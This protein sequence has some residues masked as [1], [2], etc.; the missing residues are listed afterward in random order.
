MD[1]LK[2]TKVMLQPNNWQTSRLFEY[3]GVARFAYNWALNREME[4]LSKG[5]GFISDGKLRKEFTQLKRQ[6]DYDWLNRVSNDVPK[7]AIIDLVN[8]FRKYF[9]KRKEP[10]YKPYSKKQIEHA[11][12][13][14]KKLTVYD[15][16]H[17]PKFKSK[18]NWDDYKFYNDVYKLQ[19]TDTHVRISALSKT[20]P[21]PRQAI[22][23]SIRL[24]ETGRIPT[25][26]KIYNPRVSFDGLH[27]WISVTFEHPN[28]PLK[29]SEEG[30]GID[31]GI[32]DLAIC[33]DD[34]TYKNIN[35]TRTIKQLEKRKR[36]I[37]RS[38]SR[39]YLLNK[40]GES[41]S[42]TCNVKKAE[43]QL[44]KVNRRL[45]NIRIDYT[46]QTTSK[47]VNRKP[48]F[49][50]IEDLNISGMMRNKHLSKS[51]QD[52][53][54]YE[55]RRQLTYK[56]T[57]AQIPLVIADRWFPSSKTCICCGRINKHLK[58]KD[59]VYKCQCGNVIDRDYQASLNLKR[60]GE[61]VVG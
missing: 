15:A 7:Q 42:K 57:R 54:W 3:A 58:L 56:C 11:A 31:L 25:D 39:K 47:I 26:C 10:G 32:K 14:G 43:Y 49:I 22:R 61:Q 46:H 21:K 52:Q 23:N 36:R 1:L 48:K 27:W 30:V 16:K 4:S 53:C 50:C 17:H 60:Y 19:V 18:R 20:G 5:Q 37:Q 8:A 33:S 40:K 55:L 6:P 34:N 24:A 2:A 44:L 13:V 29:L 35:K 38:I 45:T 59:R 9:K 12:R 41:Y 51:I 28:Q